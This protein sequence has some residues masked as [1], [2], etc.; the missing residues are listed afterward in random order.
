MGILY[1]LVGYKTLLDELFNHLQTDWL[2]TRKIVDIV[3]CW[4]GGYTIVFE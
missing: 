3:D 4:L 2:L 1:S